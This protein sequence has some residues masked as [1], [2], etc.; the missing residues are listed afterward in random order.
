MTDFQPGDTIE[1]VF[2]KTDSLL[3]QDDFDV[4]IFKDGQTSNVGFTITE[5][6]TAGFYSIK[7]TTDNTDEAIWSLDVEYSGDPL[8]AYQGS[9]KVRVAE[10]A[11][12]IQQNSKT[13]NVPTLLSDI[14]IS[15]DNM[16][17][18]LRLE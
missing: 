15:V 9:W 6:T 2:G 16:K 11:N 3:V 1:D 17:E 10:P 8:A 14:K 5:T 4:A 7:F 12:T 18:R 13:N